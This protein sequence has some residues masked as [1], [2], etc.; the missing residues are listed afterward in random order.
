MSV[1]R[2]DRSDSA[3][4]SRRRAAAV[5]TG[6]PFP[7]ASVAGATALTLF[8]G[9]VLAYAVL[10]QGSGYRDPVELAD[11]AVPGVRVADTEDVNTGHTEEPV[12]YKTDQPPVAGQMAS[13]TAPCGTAFPTQPP[14]EQVMHSMEHGAVWVTYRPDLPKQQVEQLADRARGSVIVS[15]FKGLK[16]AVTVQAWA[17]SLTLDGPDD[18]RLEKFI[19]A[20]QGGPQAPEGGA[21]C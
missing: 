16:A 2:R 5:A 14:T 9:G 19:D 18:P 7:W 21:G 10:N 4:A 17:R 15:P 3:T 13:A 6:R 20:Y 11:E 12:D 8:L 1:R